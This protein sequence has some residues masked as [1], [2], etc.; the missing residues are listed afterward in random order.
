MRDFIHAF[1]NEK[2]GATSVEYGAVAVFISVA[3][4]VAL[5]VISP[6]VKDIYDLIAAPH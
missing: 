3:I 4:L 1:W 6:S 5:Q 2:S